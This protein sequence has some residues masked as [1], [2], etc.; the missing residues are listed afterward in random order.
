MSAQSAGGDTGD[1]S[2]H[3]SREFNLIEDWL[4]EIG[5]FDFSPQN[6]NMLR[7]RLRRVMK[8]FEIRTFA[9]LGAKL[10]S[11]EG[12]DVQSAVVEAVTTNHTKFFR[13]KAVLSYFES[14][15]LPRYKPGSRLRIWSAACSTGEEAYSLAIIASR[16]LGQV[17]ASRQISILGTDISQTVVDAAALGQFNSKQIANLS[18]SQ[19]QQFF[20]T[21]DSNTFKV[22]APLRRMC[23]F[24]R[25]NLNANKYPFNNQ[26]DVVFCRNVLYYLAPEVQSE[27]LVKIHERTKTHGWLITSVAESVRNLEALWEPV[28]IGVYRRVGD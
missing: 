15:I 5:G 7:S 4:K 22:N 10:R 20:N 25:L 24:R 23:T 19:I 27:I 13:E 8:Q 11:K 12:L 16:Q 3:G 26:F 2:R 1:V 21:G 9:D 14:S 6:H 28:A 18:S 17:D